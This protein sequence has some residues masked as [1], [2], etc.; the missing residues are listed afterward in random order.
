MATKFFNGIRVDVPDDW[1]DVS[2]LVLAPS[3]A[4]MDGASPPINLAVKRRPGRWDAMQSILEYVAFMEHSF[5]ELRNVEIRS[6]FLGKVAGKAVR[7]EALADGKWFRQT[8]Y[9]YP[10]GD[11]EITATVTQ[12][13]E[14]STP[15]E[16]VERILQSVSLAQKGL[17]ASF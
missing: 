16:Q 13:E 5:K 12:T 8:T 14:D 3:Q 15:T 17:Y 9:I 1:A 6:L 2:T 4:L 11:E 7:F 10:C